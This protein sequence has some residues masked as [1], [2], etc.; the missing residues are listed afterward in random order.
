[1]EEYDREWCTKVLKRLMAWK[2]ARP[3][4]RPV[5]PQRDHAP[6]YYEK[7]TRPVDFESIRENLRAGKYASAEQFK[8]DVDQLC[9]NGVTYNG[10][11]SLLGLFCV[12][13]RRFMQKKYSEK[14]RDKRDQWFKKLARVSK[15]LREHTENAPVAGSEGA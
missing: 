11:N 2:I 5:D 14:A 6:D 1:M 3:F 4:L 8:D 15:K 9:A 10:Q 13:I 7:I 12:D